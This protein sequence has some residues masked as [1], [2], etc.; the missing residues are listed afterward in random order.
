ME[1]RVYQ[2]VV[3]RAGGTAA[4]GIVLLTVRTGK[5]RGIRKGKRQGP[6]SGGSVEKLGMGHPSFPD[7]PD[8][9][10]LNFSMTGD[11][12]ETQNNGLGLQIRGKIK[13]LF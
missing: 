6:A 10:L 4:A 9:P 7:G 8:E 13:I 1:V 11:R 5:K 3:F 2:P 12:S